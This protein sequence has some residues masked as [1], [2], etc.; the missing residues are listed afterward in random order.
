M[1]G[2]P[3]GRARAP[4]A[5]LDVHSVDCR[6]SAG[7]GDCRRAV[8]AAAEPV[9]EARDAAVAAWESL[10]PGAPGTSW[11]D[12]KVVATLRPADATV[13]L[14][15]F[16]L[17][18]GSDKKATVTT[19]VGLYTVG[20]ADHGAPT[21]AVGAQAGQWKEYNKQWQSTTTGANFR[22]VRDCAWAIARAAGLPLA[23]IAGPAVSAHYGRTSALSWP[24]VWGH[25]RRAGTGAVWVPPSG[26][27]VVRGVPWEQIALVPRGA[28]EMPLHVAVVPLE[29]EQRLFTVTKE[30][31]A[32]G[33]KAKVPL[34]VRWA[35]M[36][37]YRGEE[38]ERRVDSAALEA[39]IQLLEAATRRSSRW[40]A[41][42]SGRFV[43]A[44]ARAAA[45]ERRALRAAVHE[46]RRM[47][48]KMATYGLGNGRFKLIGSPRLGRAS[49]VNSSEVRGG[50]FVPK[51]EAVRRRNAK[52]ISFPSLPNRHFL[53]LTRSLN[54]EEFVATMYGHD[55]W[56]DTP[57]VVA[58][59]GRGVVTR[60][61]WDPGDDTGHVDVRLA[62]GRELQDVSAY[63]LD[64]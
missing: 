7:G 4:R 46:A 59:S 51:V 56:L 36:L 63:E 43:P 44:L 45:R 8:C 3:R 33:L 49:L 11:G 15:T 47:A 58:S 37:E 14:G 53:M 16:L 6:P 28:Q 20:L 40:D 22:A 50:R 19:F 32:Q 10:P 9:Q 61:H 54:A 17:A 18:D 13:V 1:E 29:L 24:L 55:Y 2:P 34:D 60:V 42:T 64:L 48:A 39:R 41:G 30:H 31:K 5:A 25:T 52:I 62:G 21:L 38:G 26:G 23:G 35:L 12:G 27:V 57:V